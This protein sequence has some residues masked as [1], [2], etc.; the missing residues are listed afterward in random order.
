MSESD[1]NDAGATTAEPAMVE[2][3]LI[4]KPNKGE[5][6]INAPRLGEVRFAWHDAVSL[7]LILKLGKNRWPSSGVKLNAGAQRPRFAT[8]SQKRR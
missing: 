7:K 1:R 4:R 2:N 5:R 3:D 8:D 6:L